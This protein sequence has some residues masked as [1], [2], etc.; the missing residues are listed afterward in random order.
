MD[1]NGENISRQ[2]IITG[3]VFDKYETHAS[4]VKGY[5]VTKVP[6]NAKGVMTEEPI[7]VKYIY[8]KE[9][10]P[11]VDTGDHISYAIIVNLLVLII[12]FG[13]YFFMRKK[14]YE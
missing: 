4:D 1:E 12:I 5:R 2:S 11:V 6:E 3:K 14:Y 13:I 8:E 7:T 10:E 9:P